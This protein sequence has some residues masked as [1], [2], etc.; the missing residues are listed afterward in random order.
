MA[1][2]TEEGEMIRMC[3]NCMEGE[4]ERCEQ[5]RSDKRVCDCVCWMGRVNSG[6]KA[7]MEDAAK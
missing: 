6:A 4:H 2:E 5:D 1:P 7:K 3:R